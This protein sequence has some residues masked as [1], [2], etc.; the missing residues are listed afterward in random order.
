[1]QKITLEEWAKAEFKTPPSP[2]TLRKWAR[3]GKIFPIPVRHGHRYY[4]EPGAH[5]QEPDKRPAKI[6][7]GSLVSR[8]AEARHVTKAA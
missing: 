6:T 8:I 3:E 5:Y 2:D 1:M 4:V 7:G